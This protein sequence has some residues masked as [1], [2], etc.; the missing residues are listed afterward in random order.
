MVVLSWLFDSHV[1][2]S[3]NYTVQKGILRGR[4]ALVSDI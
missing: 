2:E 4:D 3:R 1:K